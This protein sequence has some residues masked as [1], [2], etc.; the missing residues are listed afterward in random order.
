MRNAEF[1]GR[2]TPEIMPDK[3]RGI[4]CGLTLACGRIASLSAPF[5][6]T[7]GDVYSSVPIFICCGL[8]V[9]IGVV[10]L[11]FPF[12]PRDMDGSS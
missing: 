8:F 11:A 7:W 5:I 6:A 2:Y 1:G 12:E 3:Y 9:V 10:A 4:G